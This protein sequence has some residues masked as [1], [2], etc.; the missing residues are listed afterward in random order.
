MKTNLGTQ[1]PA[2]GM[3]NGPK[4]TTP[5]YASTSGTNVVA[6]SRTTRSASLSVAAANTVDNPSKRTARTTSVNA[7][8]AGTKKSNPTNS[9]GNLKRSRED[10]DNDK[11]SS[12][13]DDHN[14]GEYGSDGEEEEYEPEVEVT[15]G[16]VFTKFSRVTPCNG[17][18]ANIYGGVIP[19][20]IKARDA[21]LPKP[22]TLGNDE[23]LEQLLMGMSTFSPGKAHNPSEHVPENEEKLEAFN[24]TKWIK[25]PDVRKCTK[26]NSMATACPVVTEHDDATGSRLGL[27][28]NVYCHTHGLEYEQDKKNGGRKCLGVSLRD[29]CANADG[30]EVWREGYTLCKKCELGKQCAKDGCTRTVWREGYALCKVCALGKQCAKDGC[31]RTVW[32]EGS[33]LC[34][35]CEL[36][37]KCISCEKPRDYANSAKCKKCLGMRKCRKCDKE[38]P[39]CGGV[40]CKGCQPLC[41]QPNC[42]EKTGKRGKQPT[43]GKQKYQPKCAKC[44]RKSKKK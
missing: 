30:R 9:M 28:H 3:C 13:E 14:G 24:N 43:S 41:K 20:K 36:D 25:L 35:T 39:V 5:N 31:T 38:W 4:N 11:A 12:S 42:W 1:H 23:L 40:Y 44:K 18:F 33:A 7:T 15:S 6:G 29:N 10:D 34:R 17:T 16:G 32:R 22:Y 27:Y 19:H 21:S 37:K 2:C 26:C 8:Q